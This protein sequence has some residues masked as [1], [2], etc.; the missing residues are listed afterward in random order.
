MAKA[1]LRFSKGLPIENETAANWLA[2]HGANLFGHD[3]VPLADRVRWVKDNEAR[4][5]ATAADPLESLWW[6]EADDKH[7]WQFLAWCLEW[8]GFVKQGYG[9]VSHL[10][11]ALD[12]SCNGLQHFSAML[13][14]PIGG[15][16]VNLTPAK[17]PQDIYQRVADVTMAKLKADAEGSDT[18]AT[19]AKA[20]VAYNVS[21]SLVK[22]PV[23]VLPYGGTRHSCRKYI[24]ECLR[25]EDALHN[26]NPKQGQASPFNTDAFKAS[27]YLAGV[28][29]ASIGEVVV[30]A[31]QVMAWLKAVAST[32]SVE[33]LPITW[34]TPAGFP[35]LQAYRKLA[36]HQIKTK[37]GDTVV[38]LTL[39]EETERIDK[40][41]QANGISPN[42]VHSMDAAALMLCVAKA[43]QKGI[44]DFAVVHDSYGTHAATT[45]LLAKALRESFVD[46]YHRSD[47]LSVFRSEV[48]EVL[49]NPD[50][51]PTLP[52]RGT[53]DLEGVLKSDFFFA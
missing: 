18:K 28:V 37:L 36:A 11:V 20:W 42:F 3:K 23:M 51:L 35:V 25:A 33:G 14:D 24:L 49:E 19:Y 48:G 13:L 53:L 9:F 40:K 41:R 50:S 15:A 27:T 30:A 12:G 52:E 46:M 38:Y 8:A 45:H 7:R 32:V 44:E 5:L 17:Q 29:W 6:D 31:R 39:V 43:G 34:T 2:I 10:P 4:I 21:R 1:L 16:A 26:D 47:V 22:R